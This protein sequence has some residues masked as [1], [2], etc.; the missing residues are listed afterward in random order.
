MILFKQGVYPLQRSFQ[1]VPGLIYT[2][3]ISA[4]IAPD[5]SGPATYLVPSAPFVASPLVSIT[6][7]ITPASYPGGSS[8]VSFPSSL[9]SIPSI[10]GP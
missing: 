5:S 10:T 3:V 8:I 2:A 6:P 7:A 1:P 4:K 9:S